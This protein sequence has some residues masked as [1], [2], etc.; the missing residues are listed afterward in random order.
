MPADDRERTKRCPARAILVLES[1]NPPE[2]IET[3]VQRLEIVSKQAAPAL[4]NSAEMRA[5]R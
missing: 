4:Y 3:L 2:Q 1:F 5:S